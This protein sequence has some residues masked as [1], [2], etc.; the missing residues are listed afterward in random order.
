MGQYLNDVNAKVAGLLN[1]GGDLIKFSGIN[2]GGGDLIKYDG[3]PVAGKPAAN[4]YEDVRSEVTIDL[5]CPVPGDNPTD[6]NIFLERFKAAK[7]FDVVN[8]PSGTGT[9]MFVGFDDMEGR[10]FTV[11]TRPKLNIQF[12]TNA[13]LS[14]T[15]TE[16][17]D[18]AD[19]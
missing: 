8:P 14:V 18:T 9:M 3:T 10:R 15:I 11:S 1:I 16:S 2:Q 6:W 17:G 19:A 5:T 4:Y 12:Q 13:E 7:T